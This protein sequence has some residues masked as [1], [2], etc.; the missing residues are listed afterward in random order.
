MTHA[1]INGL[2][3][4]SGKKNNIDLTIKE[5]L[6]LIEAKYPGAGADIVDQFSGVQVTIPRTL[7]MPVVRAMLVD[8]GAMSV[9]ELAEA[10]GVSCG[11][12]HRARK[13][14]ANPA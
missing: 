3:R 9:R 8:D 14:R 2:A 4:Y 10:A 1:D 11:T 12:A 7:D 13:S 5:F 6:I